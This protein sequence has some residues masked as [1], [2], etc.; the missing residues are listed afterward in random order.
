ML[1]VIIMFMP[2]L[3]MLSETR[4]YN[5]YNKIMFYVINDID[6]QN[7]VATSLFAC[8]FCK[9]FLYFKFPWC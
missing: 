1:L 5:M 3:N 7:Q 6:L 2:M 8:E 9:S 4:E